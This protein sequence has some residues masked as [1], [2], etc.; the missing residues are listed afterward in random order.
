MQAEGTC[1]QTLPEDTEGTGR[2]GG[3]QGKDQKQGEGEEGT[4]ENAAEPEQLENEQ[5]GV[6]V[7]GLVAAVFGLREAVV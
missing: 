4:E 1:G 7:L 5:R 6:R 2:K 3:D